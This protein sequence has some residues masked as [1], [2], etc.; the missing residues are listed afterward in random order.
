LLIFTG[1]GILSS[2]KQTTKYRAVSMVSGNKKING[3]NKA[4]P[5]EPAKPACR[6][7]SAK[8]TPFLLAH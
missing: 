6:F 1:I 8:A 2:L 5:A 4:N 7:A 3:Y